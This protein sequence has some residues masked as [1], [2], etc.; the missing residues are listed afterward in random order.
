MTRSE[1]EKVVSELQEKFS[2]SRMV[3]LTD[4]KGLNVEKI[5]QLRRNLRENSLEYEVVKNSI[6][7]LASKGTVFEVMDSFF[8]GP[9][10]LAM[11]F[12]DSISP[13]RVLVNFAKD[14]PE[15]Q[16]KAGVLGGEM[17]DSS[18]IS[19]LASLPGREVLL[20]MLL[21]ALNSPLSGLVGI[22]SGVPRK[23]VHVLG[24]IKLQKEK[25]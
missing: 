6:L 21:S 4:Y 24:A 11:S 15:L 2:R 19:S 22:L 1:K 9:N 13:A 5:N 25:K 16:I 20:G 12:D 23:F 17:I 10:A 18:Q 3:I 8:V 14:N 7:K